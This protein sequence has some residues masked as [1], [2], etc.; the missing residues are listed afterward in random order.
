MAAGEPRDPDHVLRRERDA[1][2]VS[3]RRLRAKPE[4]Q[5][6]KRLNI[7]LNSQDAFGLSFSNNKEGSANAVHDLARRH[8]PAGEYSF[9]GSNLQLRSGDQRAF[10]GGMFINDGEFY[11]GERFG[12]TTFIGW[13]EPAFPHQLELPIQRDLVPRQRRR[14][15]RR[16]AYRAASTLGLRVRHA[17]RAVVARGDLLVAAV[18]GQFDPVRQRQRHDRREQPAALDSAGGPR[19][20]S[21]CSITIFRDDPLTPRRRLPFVVRRGHVEVQLHVPI[22]TGR[23]TMTTSQSDTRVLRANRSVAA[24]ARRRRAGARRSTMRRRTR[25][26]TRSPTSSSSSA[27]GW[28]DLTTTARACRCRP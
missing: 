2:R 14:P 9:N 5:P 11:D 8:I 23:T 3:R 24:A 12:V 20:A 22:L 15:A 13:R 4:R 25:S 19:G 10:G 1:H 16:A 17:R 28:G 21:S 7:E 18:V 26:R 27:S 6:C